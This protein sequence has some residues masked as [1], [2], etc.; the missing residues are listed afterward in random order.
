MKVRVSWRIPALITGGGRKMHESWKGTRNHGNGARHR[1]RIST[2][3]V[4]SGGQLSIG[5]SQLRLS[6][7]SS[8][9]PSKTI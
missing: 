1:L 4:A 6:S 5:R 8:S 7:A 9:F 3:I 2:V